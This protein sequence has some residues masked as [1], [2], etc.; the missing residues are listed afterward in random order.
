MEAPWPV[1]LGWVRIAELGLGLLFVLAGL[2]K[3]SG[4]PFMVE[5]FRSLG[6]GQWLRY[7]TALV[8]LAGGALLIAGRMEYLA[9]LALAVIMVGATVASIVVFNRSCIP[10][11]LTFMLLMVLAWKHHPSEGDR[12]GQ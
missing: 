3:L 4:M 12:A 1:R 10:P 2:V 7:V 8:E 5:L 6:F 9:A 11:L